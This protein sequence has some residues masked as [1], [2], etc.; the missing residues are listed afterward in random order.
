MK[1]T[2]GI[3]HS[4]DLFIHKSS[5]DLLKKLM[6]KGKRKEHASKKRGK[7]NMEKKMKLKG[8]KRKDIR[9]EKIQEKRAGS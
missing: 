2:I 1:F 4:L 9:R 3:R 5:F 6:K 7:R 8:G